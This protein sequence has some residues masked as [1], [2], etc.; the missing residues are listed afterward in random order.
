MQGRLI[1]WLVRGLGLL[2]AIAP[3]GCGESPALPAPSASPGTEPVSL[4][5][6]HT[7][8]I[9]RGRVTSD[10][11]TPII[12]GYHAPVSPLS[13]Q[14]GGAPQHWPNP[15]RPHIDAESGGVEGAVV[16]LRQV[17]LTRARPWDLPPVTV[18][19]H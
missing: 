4:F 19:P 17:D 18:E 7:A 14:A 2:L 1:G 8:A 3:A 5:D 9:V 15:H 10:G 16:F 11:E 6:P 12:P 13:E